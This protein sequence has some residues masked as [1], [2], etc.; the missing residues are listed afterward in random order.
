M[1]NRPPQAARP[2]IGFAMPDITERAGTEAQDRV[3]PHSC[4]DCKWFVPSSKALDEFG[5]DSGI[6]SAR[7]ELIPSTLLVQTATAC[8][9]G[10]RGPNRTSTDGVILDPRY[11]LMAEASVRM[12][13]AVDSGPFD[14]FH[15]SRVD[16][17]E[18]V[19]ELPVTDEDRAAGIKAWRLVRDPQGGPHAPIP[20]PIFDSAMLFPGE[21][22]RDSYGDH[23]P[24]LY[25]DHAGLLYTAAFMNMG[26][27]RE[28]SNAINQVLAL[29][30]EAGT[31]KTEFWCYFAWL[32][33]LPF[34][35][36]SLRPDSDSLEFFGKTELVI[37][38]DTKQAVTEF[39]PARFAKYIQEPCVICLDEPNAA[40]DNIWFLL[41]PCLD[42][43]G[44]LVIEGEDLVIVPDS[45]CFIGLAMNPA[46]MTQYRGARELS[47]AD[48]DRLAT[49]SVEL[50][51]RETE[52][53]I[54]RMHCEEIGYSIPDGTLDKLM[55][56]AT[57]LR[58]LS[59]DSLM[60]PWGIRPNV[61]V[62]KYTRGFSIEAAFRLAILDRL[63]PETA[64]VVLTCVRGHA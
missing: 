23:K 21:E 45:Y 61:A 5:F 9:I 33:D 27:M 17:R 24:H 55:N 16:P 38:A 20:M 57:E 58:E 44:Q 11:D 13:G 56:I 18:W 8:E 42:S 62:A 43:A 12:G 51:E 37:D 59:G 40:P 46:W 14:P 54:V 22:V 36:L 1:H 50:P 7:A 3:A 4:T 30:G 10:N 15:H 52:M 19:T 28:G 29:I 25:V 39:R 47:P 63:D 32:L 34:R 64:N 6:C 49:R 26:G 31:G 53:A 60:I 41:R 2:V 48:A 35:R